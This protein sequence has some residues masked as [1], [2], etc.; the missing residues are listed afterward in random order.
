MINK[1]A[2]NYQRKV[3]GVYMASPSAINRWLAEFQVK[4]GFQDNALNIIKNMKN[5]PAHKNNKLF[6]HTNL[7]FDEIHIRDDCVQMDQKTQTV[8]GPYKKLQVVQIRGL[9]SK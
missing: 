4:R 5:T 1:T 9:A 8:L 3:S 6:E 7:V 2:Y